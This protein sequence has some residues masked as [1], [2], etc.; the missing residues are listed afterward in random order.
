MD[1]SEFINKYLGKN[2]DYDKVFGTQCVD[3]FRQYC[4]DVLNI[5]H[6]GG[7]DGARELYLNYDKLPLEQKYFEKVAKTEGKYRDVAIYDVTPNNPFG[8]VAMVLIPRETETLVFEQRG[9]TK[10]TSAQ[11]YW[12][13]NDK[14][15]GFLRKR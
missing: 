6:T 1:F 4:Q 15:L 13:S 7:V 9:N 11:L 5:P 2:V 10:D 12:R 3:L 8:H 14:L